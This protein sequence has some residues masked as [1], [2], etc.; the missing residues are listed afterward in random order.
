MKSAERVAE[1]EERVAELESE[2]D[3]LRSRLIAAG[4]MPTPADLPSDQQL[5]KL[6]GL[7]V[8]A[9]PQLEPR[10]EEGNFRRQF[11]NAL[12][13]LTFARRS[14]ELNREYALSFFVDQAN[15]WCRQY[16]I[17][18]GVR[19]RAFVAAAITSGVKY[20]PVVRFPRDIELGLALGGASQGSSAWH[21]V[22][23]SG[24]VPKPTPLVQRA[25]PERAQQLLIR[26]SSGDRSAGW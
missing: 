7:V 26:P 2:N 19:S 10:E 3:A 9:H 24:E 8:T 22:L 21:S 11:L 14:D 20:S 17:D 16:N 18:G 23:T 15:Q 6:I 1:L 25:R 12:H 5:D 4:L 13:F